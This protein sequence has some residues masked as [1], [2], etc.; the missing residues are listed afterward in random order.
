M[1]TLNESLRELQTARN[2]RARAL[3][4]ESDAALARA[5]EAKARLTMLKM[6]PTAPMYPQTKVNLLAEWEQA[7]ADARRL[8]GEAMDAF[9]AANR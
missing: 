3:A 9:F 4:A 8:H 5:E 7:T 6:L 1:T 2:A